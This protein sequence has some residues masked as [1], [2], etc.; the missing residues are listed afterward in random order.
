MSSIEFC[1]AII[2]CSEVSTGT[3]TKLVES[4]Q[5]VQICTQV[6]ELVVSVAEKGCFAD[7]EQSREQDLHK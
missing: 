6:C 4:V 2:M 3:Q 1:V 7:V 5:A